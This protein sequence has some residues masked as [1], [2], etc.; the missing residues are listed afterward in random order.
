MYATFYHLKT[1]PFQITCDPRFL[2]LSE[3]HEEA[4]AMLRYAVLDNRGFLLLTG[5][6]GTGKTILINHLITLL[7]ID[8]AVATLTDPD[9]TRMDFYRFLA[10]GFKIAPPT[11]SKAEFLIQLRNFLQEKAANQQ[12]VLL[13]IDEAQRLDPDLMEDIRALSN[14]EFHDRKLINIFFVGQPEF[15]QMLMGEQNRA[16]AQRITIRYQIEPLNQHETAGYIQHRLK[17]AGGTKKIFKDRAI[18]S[19]HEYSA[20][21]PRLI[22]IICDHALLTGYSRNKKKIDADVITECVGE[23]RIPAWRRSAIGIR[24]FTGSLE[25]TSSAIENPTAGRPKVSGQWGKISGKSVERHQKRPRLRK[26]AYSGIVAS[27][28]FIWVAAQIH[29]DGKSSS[30]PPENVE[31]PSHRTSVPKTTPPL[32]VTHGETLS[33]PETHNLLKETNPKLSKPVSAPVVAKEASSQRVS[34]P[35]SNKEEPLSRG[36]ASEIN[37]RPVKPV[38]VPA[39]AKVASGRHVGL[40]APNLKARGSRGPSSGAVS[41]SI[42]AAASPTEVSFLPGWPKKEDVFIQF[43]GTNQIAVTSRPAMDQVAS[44]LM[45]FPDRVIYLHGVP[46]GEGSQAQRRMRWHQRVDAVKNYLIGKGVYAY[47][48]EAHVMEAR[49]LDA[50]AGRRPHIGA[51]VE[52]PRKHIPTEY[53]P[54]K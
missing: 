7:P 18:Q 31:M 37:L 39:V 47:Q 6:V 32:M 1:K 3:K 50:S 16:L 5:E 24:P 34:R 26:W 36:K 51:V 41:Q 12:Q 54:D 29:F 45:E 11:R 13:I 38:S 19:V 52:F 27:V 14:I 23:L 48:I 35:A 42:R 17:V 8:T 44:H 49:R 2:W 28:L 46:G 10:D 53:N 40:S 15:N 4:L 20:G 33:V 25:K 22:N 9:L 43:D 30:L 21:I